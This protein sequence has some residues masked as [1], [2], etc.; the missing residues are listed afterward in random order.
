[1]GGSKKAT[2]GYKYYMGSH[3]VVADELDEMTELVFGGRTVWAGSMTASGR[4]NISKPDLFGGEKREGGF[5][6]AVD[7]CFG[8]STQVP[9]DY[10]AEKA[11]SP[12]PAFRGLWSLVLRQCY[13][14]ANNPYIKALWVRGGR[15]CKTWYTEKAMW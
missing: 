9:N 10:L 15:W 12:Q 13:L 2:I 7:V 1:M 5:E 6:G 3:L 4:L 8:E 11:G 14:A